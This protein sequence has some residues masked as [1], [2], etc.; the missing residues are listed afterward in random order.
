MAKSYK[1]LLCYAF[2]GEYIIYFQRS[3][4]SS[5]NHNFHLVLHVMVHDIDKKNLLDYYR[6]LYNVFDYN[7]VDC[8]NKFN[9][10]QSGAPNSGGG[11]CKEVVNI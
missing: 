7:Y 4:F 5:M 8:Y 1:V 11:G 3:M 2:L 9:K 10:P 6:Y